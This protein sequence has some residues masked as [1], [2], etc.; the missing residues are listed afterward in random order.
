MLS[1]CL[2]V[3]LPRP[4]THHEAPGAAV[5]GGGGG[6]HPWCPDSGPWPPPAE[7]W[8]PP[9]PGHSAPAAA[10]WESVAVQSSQAL[11][12]G[13]QNSQVSQVI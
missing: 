3:P 6:P 11:H 10:S 12:G 8:P 4:L 13:S 9:T 2:N 5:S 1:Q 7:P